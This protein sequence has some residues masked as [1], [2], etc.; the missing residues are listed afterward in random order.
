MLLYWPQL[1]HARCGNL[2][3]LQLEHLTSCGRRS[4]C[5]A[6]RVLL[7]LLLCFFLGKGVMVLVYYS[8][9]VIARSETTKQ[10]FSDCHARFAGLAM[11]C[12]FCLVHPTK[13]SCRCLLRDNIRYRVVMSRSVGGF[14]SCSSEGFFACAAAYSATA[15][16]ADCSMWSYRFFYDWSNDCL[17]FGSYNGIFT[18]TPLRGHSC[19]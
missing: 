8:I 17:G 4:G 5:A 3:S 2:S 11:T 6:L 19:C 14:S 13:N 10:S 16:N 9:Y 15:G 1:G 18:P 12:W 7:S